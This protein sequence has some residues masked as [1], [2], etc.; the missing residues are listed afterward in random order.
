MAV[1]Q[2]HDL[3]PELDLTHVKKDLVTHLSQLLGY[4]NDS[5]AYA[6]PQVAKDKTF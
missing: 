2:I 5:V 1:T 6:E 3:K 4:N